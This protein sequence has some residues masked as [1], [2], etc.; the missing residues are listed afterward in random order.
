M[1]IRVPEPPI[2]PAPSHFRKR[3]ERIVLV[4]YLKRVSGSFAREIESKRE[5]V[6]L[7]GIGSGSSRMAP[8]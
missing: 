6:C 5:K 4:K 8:G 1:K 3:G 7:T 2:C